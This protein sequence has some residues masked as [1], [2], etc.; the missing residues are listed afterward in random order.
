MF[1][2]FWDVAEINA[3]NSLVLNPNESLL[4]VQTNTVRAV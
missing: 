4:Y 3:G 2:S 1:D